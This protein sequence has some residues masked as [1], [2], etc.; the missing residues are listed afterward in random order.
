MAKCLMP[1][2]G[3]TPCLAPSLSSQE[4]E[5]WNGTSV[6]REQGKFRNPTVIPR[7]LLS[8]F[9]FAFL[10][11]NPRQSIPSLYQCSIPPKSFTT[12]WHGFKSSDAGYKELR[13]LF[14][15]LICIKQIGPGSGNKICIVDAEDLLAHPEETVERFCS[16][17]GV[18][19]DRGSL[20][21]GTEK[22]QQRAKDLFKNWAPFHDVALQSTSLK[23]QPSASHQIVCAHNLRCI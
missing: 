14:D 10:I 17:V 1:L 7:E 16:S 18:T 23:A 20:Q 8:K 2:H 6:L 19:F 3:E 15:Y 22:D 5:A 21:W 12:G 4:N 13:R 11:R 9:S